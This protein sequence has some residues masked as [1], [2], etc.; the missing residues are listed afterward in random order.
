MLS[1]E[2]VKR[3]SVLARLEVRPEDQDRLVRELDRI[4]GFVR[5]LE[6][7]PTGEIEPLVHPLD[8]IQPLRDDEVREPVDREA[9]QKAA[10][11][12][13]EGYYRVPRVIE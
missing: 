13:A 1:A 6:A 8:L 4:L 5:Q 9:I 3:L 10:P 12:V 7:A 11:D 2:E